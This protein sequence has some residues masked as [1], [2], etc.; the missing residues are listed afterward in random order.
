MAVIRPEARGTVREPDG[1]SHRQAPRFMQW[2][3]SAWWAKAEFPR[4]GL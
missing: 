2:P 3:I 1:A 4:H